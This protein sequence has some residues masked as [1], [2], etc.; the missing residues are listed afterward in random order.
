MSY[1]PVR[2]LRSVNASEAHL[3]SYL[4]FRKHNEALPCS[5]EGARVHGTAWM[6][7]STENNCSP[8][9]TTWHFTT[10]CH[11]YMP[12]TKCHMGTTSLKWSWSCW[13]INQRRRCGFRCPWLVRWVAR[14]MILDVS[15]K[16]TAFIFKGQGVIFLGMLGRDWAMHSF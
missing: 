2:I 1:P 11:L 9:T 15:T 13:N 6:S 3:G 8:N 5:R 7:S 4:H 10:Y 12:S 16:R 14:L